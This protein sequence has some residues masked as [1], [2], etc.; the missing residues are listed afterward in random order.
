MKKKSDITPLKL[1]VSNEDEPSTD[2]TLAIPKPSM[3][4]PPEGDWLSPLECGTEFKCRNKTGRSPPW[5]VLEYTH[6][7]KLK[8]DVLLCPTVSINNPTSW[9]WVEPVMFCR[10]WEFRGVISQPELPEETQDGR[11]DSPE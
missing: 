2:L 1:V 8:G 3:K 5:L 6:M 11:T 4:E 9:F 7:G 10:E